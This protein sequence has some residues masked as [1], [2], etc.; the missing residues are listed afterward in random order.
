MRRSR[1]LLCPHCNHSF[2]A[3]II[4]PYTSWRRQAACPLLFPA[5]SSAAKHFRCHTVLLH[6]FTPPAAN[7]QITRGPAPS[8]GQWNL[9]VP[10]YMRLNWRLFLTLVFSVSLQLSPWTNNHC[11][12]PSLVVSYEI[13]CFGSA[14]A[15]QFSSKSL[16]ACRCVKCGSHPVLS[17][18]CTSHIQIYTELVFSLY[19]AHIVRFTA[20][21]LKILHKFDFDD[22]SIYYYCSKWRLAA[23]L[24]TYHTAS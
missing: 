13:L 19:L 15:Q 23:V 6:L 16:C 9:T 4:I 17:I 14:L 7:Q 10:R 18:D 21:H 3:H 11:L 1:V 8:Y 24:P 20:L 2:R 5:P 22:F 12:N